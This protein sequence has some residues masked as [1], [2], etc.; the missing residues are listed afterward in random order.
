MSWILH[1][2]AGAKTTASLTFDE[3]DPK[4]YGCL[5][6]VGGIGSPI[7]L[8]HLKND[9]AVIGLF[10]KHGNIVLT[11]FF[12]LRLSLPQYSTQEHPQKKTKSSQKVDE[13]FSVGKGEL[14]RGVKKCSPCAAS[15]SGGE[16]GSPS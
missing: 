2:N 6:I 8:E 3:V 1:R 12:W 14:K 10:R 7:F 5:A 16:R 4:R 15:P 11:G 9:H 13:K